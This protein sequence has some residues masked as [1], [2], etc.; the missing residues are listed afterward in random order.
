[1]RLF[2]M[3]PEP[4]V[5]AHDVYKDFDGLA[6]LYHE[7]TKIAPLYSEEMLQGTPGENPMVVSRSQLEMMQRAFKVYESAPQIKLPALKTLPP[8][9]ATFQQVIERRRTVRNFKPVDLSL[10]QLSYLCNLTY[11]IT[12]GSLH[13]ATK[14]IQ[15]FRACPS[16][17]ALYPLEIYLVPLQP[18]GA[19]SDGLY[20]YNVRNNSLE[21]LI[22]RPVA[23]QLKG[24]TM[25]NQP[26]D[27]RHIMNEGS[28]AVI[29]TAV[30]GRII[31]K[32]GARGYRYIL[33]EAGHAMQNLLLAA[34]ACNLQAFQSAAFDDDLLS[35]LLN[36]H[37]VEEAPLY[38]AVLG[39]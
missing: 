7:N 34:Q 27:L 2:T 1:M 9:P 19:L 17:G 33:F 30:M 31:G 6:E 35:D 24:V 20:H 11:G 23:N 26:A 25:N 14:S 37:G 4:F 8:L 5:D 36:I 28:L 10:E 32:Y 16:G 21:V 39:G 15:F 18:N 12:S 22:D 29:F 3:V 13:E 38:Y